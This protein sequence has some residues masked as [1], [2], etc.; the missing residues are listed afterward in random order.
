MLSVPSAG[1]GAVATPLAA[2]PTGN[3]FLAELMQ[4]GQQ[5]IVSLLIVGVWAVLLWPVRVLRHHLSPPPLTVYLSS[6]PDDLGSYRAVAIA[7]LKRL[8]APRADAPKNAG[9]EPAELADRLSQVRS[10]GLFIGLYAWRYGPAET[11]VGEDGNQDC[12]SVTDHELNEAQ[13]SSVSR[14]LWMVDERTFW[15]V[16][17]VDEP[18][19]NVLELRERVAADP[20][21]RKLPSDPMALSQQVE[22]AV[23]DRQRELHSRLQLVADLTATSGLVLTVVMGVL[24][25]ASHILS[26]ALNHTSSNRAFVAGVALTASAAV[27]GI[28]FLAVRFP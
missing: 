24:A 8:G 10:C 2:M 7:A 4:A 5:H 1:L 20:A 28:R 12:R 11:R 14:A 22:K 19:K 23:V 21:N 6:T 15:P 27:Y 26:D 17:A 16:T 13:T 3:S 9:Q 18:R 25:V